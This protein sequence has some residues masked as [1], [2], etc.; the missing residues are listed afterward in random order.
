VGAGDLK[1]D[2]AT[3]KI[4]RRAGRIL[5]CSC[6]ST[7]PC[8]QTA[9]EGCDCADPC[10]SRGGAATLFEVGFGIVWTRPQT[11][12][13]PPVGTFP[14]R[15]SFSVTLAFL[16][17]GVAQ[18]VYHAH[19]EGPGSG[20]NVTVTYHEFGTG[21]SASQTQFVTGSM[22]GGC[23]VEVDGL[24][25]FIVDPP[26][27]SCWDPAGITD[28]SGFR[29]GDCTS[30]REEITSR[31]PLVFPCSGELSMLRNT[32]IA[33]LFGCSP[34][35]ECHRGACCCGDACYDGLTA[36]EC[37]GQAGVY[38]GDGSSC[39]SDPCPPPK[40]ACCLGYP[41]YDC[42]FETEAACE[43]DG[44]QYLGDGVLC[45]SNLC[46]PIL[47]ACCFPDASCTDGETPLGC[48]GAG[49]TF[50]GNGTTC[51]AAQCDPLRGACCYPDGF[52]DIETHHD[53]DV[54]AGQYRGDNTTC[55]PASCPSGACCLPSGSCVTTGTLGCSQ[56]SGFYQGDGSLCADQNCDG[57][58]CIGGVGTEM[59]ETDCIGAGGTWHGPNTT[60]VSGSTPTAFTGSG[61]QVNCGLSGTAFDPFTAGVAFVGTGA[62]A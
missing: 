16:Q 38:K 28:V 62:F 4:L 30:F 32:R 37:T 47:G 11:C 44:G 53:C 17:A 31:I 25:L 27:Y 43:A 21:A 8:G 13:C 24:T 20:F 5:E 15:I 42:A 3:G 26:V 2:A 18:A 61:T 9:G 6:C 12:C 51:A 39:E 34:A 59:S 22:A 40:G 60:C 33:V 35:T 41:T 19:G 55:N 29:Y 36:A 54:H 46:P 50:Q 57:C 14:Q 49:G 48:R 1:R 56:S 45:A 10:V 58:C 7:T 52:C 23:S